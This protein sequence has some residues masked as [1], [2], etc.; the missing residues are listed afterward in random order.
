MR[1]QEKNIPGLNASIHP[2]GFN[3]NFDIFTSDFR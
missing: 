1:F 2:L 3:L